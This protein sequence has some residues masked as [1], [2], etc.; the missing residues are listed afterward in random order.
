MVS[1]ICFL[2]ELGPFL[3]EIHCSSRNNDVLGEKEFKLFERVT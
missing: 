1:N 3:E 2:R